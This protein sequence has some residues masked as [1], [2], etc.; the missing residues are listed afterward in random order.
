LSPA[1]GKRL[2]HVLTENDRVLKAV[3]AMKSADLVSLGKLMQESHKSM[4]DDFEITCDEVDQIVAICASV[5]GV[6]GARMT[7][8]GFGGCVVAL[9]KPGSVNELVAKVDAAY[10]PATQMFVVEASGGARI[11]QED[12]RKA[13][14]LVDTNFCTA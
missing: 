13:S 9:V 1:H 7:G 8:G 10:K 14:S 4:R 11:I 3:N 2:R 6:Y 5:P 12:R